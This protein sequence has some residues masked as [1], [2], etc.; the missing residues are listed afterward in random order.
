MVVGCAIKKEINAKDAKD[1]KGA[2]DARVK[3][4]RN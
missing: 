2:K 1:A 4:N 3:R